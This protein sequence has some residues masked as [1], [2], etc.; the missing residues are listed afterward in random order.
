MERSV[1]AIATTPVKGFAL[2]SPE[3]VSLGVDGLE[4]NRRFALLDERGER[5]RSSKHAWPC[6]V[7]ADYDVETEHLNIRLPDG[8]TIA[9]TVATTEAVAFDYH[10]HLVGAHVV[11]GPWIGPL[12]SLAG[13]PVRLVKLDRPGGVQ[14]EPV[15]LVST[16]S[17]RTIANEAGRDVD[18][19]RFRMLF[20]VDG[21]APHEEDEW[22]GRRVRIGE[23]VVRVVELVERCVV[24]TR[25]PETGRR[26]LDT[27]ALLKGYRG[28]IDFGVRATVV[29]P[30]VVGVGGVVEPLD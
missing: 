4:A 21:C 2:S 14:S 18:A 12:S 7:A 9:G 24:T 20:H 27:L 13:I 28:S 11:A 23:A 3:H 26:D 10:G 16:A 6:T 25:D 29:E 1:A 8:R 22:L 19:R 17:L 15:T 30:G 5:L